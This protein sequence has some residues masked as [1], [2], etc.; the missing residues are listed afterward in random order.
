MT[1]AEGSI[2]DLWPEPPATT[3]DRVKHFL[4]M[5]DDLPDNF[6]ILLT[7][8]GVYGRHVRTGVSLGDLRKL[9][10]RAYARTETVSADTPSGRLLGRLERPPEETG[11]YHRPHFND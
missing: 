10:E 9:Y 11:G 1:M 6:M 5:F 2:K 8:A 4:D 7:T 3:P